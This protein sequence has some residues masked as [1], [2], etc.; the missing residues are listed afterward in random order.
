MTPFSG[1][2]SHAPRMVKFSAWLALR[3][4]TRTIVPMLTASVLALA[5]SVPRR[6]RVGL[7]FVFAAHE[8]LLHFLGGLVF[9]VFA[10]VAVAAGDG[11]F[12]GVG[13]DFF[14]NE[15]GIFVLAAFE[16]FPGDDEIASCF[17]C[18]PEMRDWIAG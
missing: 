16:T 5:K 8:E 18:S 10:E 3:S 15:F 13:R 2:E 14:L 1:S 17:V 4:M 11:D 9:V 6:A 12:L 7:Q